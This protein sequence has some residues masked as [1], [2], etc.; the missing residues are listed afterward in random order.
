M[1]SKT[2]AILWMITGFMFM[3]VLLLLVLVIASNLEVFF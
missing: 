1:K 3:E 2:W